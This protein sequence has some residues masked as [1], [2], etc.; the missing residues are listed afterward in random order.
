MSAEL[1]TVLLNLLV[2]ALH[3]AE[4]VPTPSEPPESAWESAADEYCYRAARTSEF[5]PLSPEVA[6][7]LIPRL[8]IA[9]VFASFVESAYDQQAR[10]GDASAG[11][12]KILESL[13]VESWH[14]S[15]KPRWLL[16]ELQ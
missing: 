14:S 5:E 6:S 8:R 9:R 11:E 16:G 13:L 4:R 1:D 10:L 3:T 7:A 2:V 12:R 15:W